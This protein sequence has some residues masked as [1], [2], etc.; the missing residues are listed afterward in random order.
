MVQVGGKRSRKLLK[1]GRQTRT[2]ERRMRR[3]RRKLQPVGCRLHQL[4]KR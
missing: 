2:K 4:Q 1:E 3:M